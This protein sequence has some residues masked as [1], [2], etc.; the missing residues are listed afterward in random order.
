MDDLACHSNGESQTGERLDQSQMQCHHS[1]QELSQVNCAVV[2]YWK[3]QKGSQSSASPLKCQCSTFVD[4]VLEVIPQKVA[5][6][7]QGAR[8]ASCRAPI[9]LN[10]SKPELD[11]ALYGQPTSTEKERQWGGQ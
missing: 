2:Q 11:I 9:S 10:E 3:Q 6:E 7:C 8:D 4:L 5:L 1:A